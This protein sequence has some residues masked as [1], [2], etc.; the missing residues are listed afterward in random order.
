MGGI[1]QYQLAK[2][3]FV[4]HYLI[5]FHPFH[6]CG[7]ISSWI[8]SICPIPSHPSIT[9]TSRLIPLSIPILPCSHLFPFLPIL[10]IPL[11]LIPWPSHILGSLNMLFPSHPVLLT[12]FPSHLPLYCLLPSHLIWSVFLNLDGQWSRAL[13]HFFKSKKR[14]ISRLVNY[15]WFSMLS[16]LSK[17]LKAKITSTLYLINWLLLF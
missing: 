11:R 2:F 16:I 17:V 3:C 9:I 6:S 5:P 4:L 8:D 1:F 7:P 13:A 15:N 14:F 12:P 10:P